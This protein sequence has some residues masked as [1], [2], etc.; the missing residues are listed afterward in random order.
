MP[1]DDNHYRREG[2]CVDIN[3]FQS[4]NQLIDIEFSGFFE[5]NLVVNE[6]KIYNAK[7]TKGISFSNF[8]KILSCVYKIKNNGD[9]RINGISIQEDKIAKRYIQNNTLILKEGFIFLHPDLSLKDNIKIASLLHCGFDLSNAT[10]S[11]FLMKDFENVKV[12]YLTKEQKQMAILSYCVACPSILWVIDSCLINNLSE[13]NR[14]IFENTLKI[15]LK[16]GG[17]VIF[18]EQ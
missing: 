15:R 5:N 14:E 3:N 6:A 9:I 11:S 16:H 17:A 12:F 13:Q 10:L 4:K 1:A 8:A 2:D 7:L 18:V